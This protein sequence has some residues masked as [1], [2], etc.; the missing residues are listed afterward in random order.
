MES[1]KDSNDFIQSSNLVEKKIGHN[2]LQTEIDSLS[3]ALA[4]KEKLLSECQSQITQLQ[5]KCSSL[6]GL[7]AQLVNEKTT[8]A[9][10]FQATKESLQ[11]SVSSDVLK[12]SNQK[13]LS[14][15]SANTQTVEELNSLKSVYEDTQKQLVE[16]LSLVDELK[17]SNTNLQVNFDQLSAEYAISAEQCSAL[18]SERSTLQNNIDAQLL[19]INSLKDQ[20]S[21]S[22]GVTLELNTI[23]EE[24][25]KE[26]ELLSVSSLPVIAEGNNVVIKGKSVRASKN[27]R[28]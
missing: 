26:I 18:R 28:R 15:Q 21:H 14:L 17:F 1:N 8:L 12:E 19:E 9:D 25:T 2:K 5:Q 13:I 24:K 3:K 22:K 4:E 20:I 16:A 6:E 27:S 10:E 23:I 7:H 11:N